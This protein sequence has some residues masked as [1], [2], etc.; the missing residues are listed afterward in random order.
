M[1][2]L[3]Y[4]PAQ[5]QQDES[6]DFDPNYD[7]SDFLMTKKDS[8]EEQEPMQVQEAQSYQEGYDYAGAIQDGAGGDELQT[9]QQNFYGAY[10]QQSF[11][12]GDY[13]FQ[14]QSQTMMQEDYSQSQPMVVSD[15]GGLADLEISDS[16][17]EDQ[18]DE[19][20]SSENH[21]NTSKEDEGGLWF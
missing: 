13:S 12:V 18:N 17:D 16:D 9:Q 14:S 10:A 3:G 11:G 19:N 7:P 2:Q 8:T 4:Y 5:Q 20:N 15:G 1:I 21:A 6:M